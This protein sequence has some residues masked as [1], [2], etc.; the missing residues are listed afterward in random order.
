MKNGMTASKK[1]RQML[2]I[3]ELMKEDKLSRGQIAKRTGIHEQMLSSYLSE[4][5]KLKILV[6]NPVHK[7]LNLY[8]L[9][10]EPK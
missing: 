6:A 1:K 3:K 7:N 10:E 5:C 8:S 2:I 9:G 4:M